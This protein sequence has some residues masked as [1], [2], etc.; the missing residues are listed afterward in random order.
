MRNGRTPFYTGLRG[1]NAVLLCSSLLGGCVAAPSVPPRS[2]V[3]EVTQPAEGAAVSGDAAPTQWW[4][5]Y[6]EPALDALV[7]E[8]LTNNRDLRVA[9]ANLLKA[10]AILGEARGDRIPQTELSAGVGYGST[11]QDQIAAAAKGVSSARTGTRYD[12]G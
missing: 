4:R 1:V 11:L 9:E 10:R 5:L 2:T 3:T 8:A 12:L 7:T 6:N